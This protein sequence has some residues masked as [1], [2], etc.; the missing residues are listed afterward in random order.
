MLYEI[1]VEYDDGLFAEG[2][3]MTEKELT[4]Y[5][6]DM[7]RRNIS[8]EYEK[9]GSAIP[10]HYIRLKPCGIGNPEFSGKP[11]ISFNEKPRK[12]LS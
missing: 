2:Y 3:V 10:S 6:R 11:V 7:V 1:R 5:L 9:L 8:R 12:I 4:P